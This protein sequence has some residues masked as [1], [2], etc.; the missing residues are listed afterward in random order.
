MQVKE[1]TVGFSVFQHAARAS[2]RRK[3]TEVTVAMRRC[4]QPNGK[5][6]TVAGSPQQRKRTD[7]ERPYAELTMKENKL[8]P[9]TWLTGSQNTAEAMKGKFLDAD[10]IE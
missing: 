3:K 7:N 8:K 10:S 9:S 5:A 4:R 2:D 1:G 6:V